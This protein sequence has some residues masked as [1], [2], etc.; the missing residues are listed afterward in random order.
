MLIILT[1]VTQSKPYI[2]KTPDQNQKSNQKRRKSIQ[3]NK[4][5]Y[6]LAFLKL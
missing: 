1:C 2:N 4:K 3:K 6:I 5:M